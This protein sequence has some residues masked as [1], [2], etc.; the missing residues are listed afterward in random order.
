MINNTRLFSTWEYKE[1]YFIKLWSSLLPSS[2]PIDHTCIKPVLNEERTVLMSTFKVISMQFVTIWYYVE[3]SSF[4]VGIDLKANDIDIYSI[5][6]ALLCS[7]LKSR[8]N[9]YIMNLYRYDMFSEIY[10]KIDSWSYLLKFQTNQINILY[11]ASFYWIFPIVV[12]ISSI[13]YKYC[14]VFWK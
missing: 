3:T 4:L 7:L 11:K 6:F 1:N 13:F 9:E 10:K 14:T 12:D 5:R 8:A 2:I